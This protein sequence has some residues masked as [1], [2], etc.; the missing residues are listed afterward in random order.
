[1]PDR[2]ETEAFRDAGIS[3]V[4][5]D[6]C[7]LPGGQDELPGPVSRR[8]VPHDADPVPHAFHY[9]VDAPC[10]ITPVSGLS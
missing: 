3:Q 6:D 8:A 5:P 4:L 10:L 7:Y 1:M 2:I 9:R